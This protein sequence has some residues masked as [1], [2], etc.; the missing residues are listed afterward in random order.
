MNT[1]YSYFVSAKAR[2]LRW[3]VVPGGEYFETD[4]YAEA[5]KKALEFHTRWG[6][7]G[8]DR[9]VVVGPNGEAEHDD[10]FVFYTLKR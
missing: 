8:I 10:S 3:D 2:V 6:M 5:I 7:V 1:K 9:F 4:S